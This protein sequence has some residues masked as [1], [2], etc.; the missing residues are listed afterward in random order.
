MAVTILGKNEV[1]DS[2]YAA[3][4]YQIQDYRK[5]LREKVDP[6]LSIWDS[7]AGSML[8]RA[9]LRSGYKDIIHA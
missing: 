8:E 7:L 9:A 4:Y 6:T 3:I 2:L 5:K 1:R